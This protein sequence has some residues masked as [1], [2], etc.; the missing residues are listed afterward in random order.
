MLPRAPSAAKLDEQLREGL[1]AEAWAAICDAN[2][3]VAMCRVVSGSRGGR[4][5][6]SG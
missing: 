6:G 4:C 1:P 5:R 3:Q 2:D